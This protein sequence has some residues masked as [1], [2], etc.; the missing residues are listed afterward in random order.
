MKSFLFVTADFLQAN[1]RQLWAIFLWALSVGLVLLSLTALW[2]LPPYQQAGAPSSQRF[3]LLTLSPLLSEAEINRLAWDIW[4]W[5]EV[6]KVSFRFPGENDPEPVS[7]RTLVVELRPGNDQEKTGAKLQKL[8]GITKVAVIERTTIP[9]QV[10][11]SAR[12]GAIAS[13][14][15]SLGLCFV[16][17]TQVIREGRR[18]WEKERKLLR[19]SG[20]PPAIW[21]G[22]ELLLAGLAGLLGAGLHIA[23]LVLG[24]KFIPPHGIWT[25]LLRLIPKAAGLGV[26]VGIVLGV[27]SAIFSPHS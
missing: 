22:P 8:S 13:L 20:V 3:F 25:E 12:I 1:L 7:E 10:P 21:R 19:E 26:P 16:L 23:A 2:A 11:S 24:A 18:R 27:L 5:P 6:A 4:S 15:L 9:P 17:G 14:V